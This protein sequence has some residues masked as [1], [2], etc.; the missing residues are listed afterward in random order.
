MEAQ[1]NLVFLVHLVRLVNPALQFLLEVPQD[2]EVLLGLELDYLE[3]LQDLETLEV[4]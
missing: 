3:H 2:L 4:P 1:V